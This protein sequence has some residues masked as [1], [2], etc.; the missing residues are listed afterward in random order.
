MLD[1]LAPRERQIVDILYQRGEA[2]VTEVREALPDALSASAV[3]AMLSRLEAKGMVDRKDSERGYLY[4][5]AVPQSEA[6]KSAL[7]QVVRVF[8]NGSAVGA[9]SALLDMNGPLTDQDLEELERLIA[10]A[11][12]AGR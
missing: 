5:P 6:T 8:F 1:A 7:D 4:A 11:K 9:A 3:R 12:K 10:E 2:T